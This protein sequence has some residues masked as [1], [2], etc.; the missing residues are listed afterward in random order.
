MINISNTKVKALKEDLEN[1][2]L[3]LPGMIND[4]KEISW[5]EISSDNEN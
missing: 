4:L 1:F 2:R 3:Y 5:M